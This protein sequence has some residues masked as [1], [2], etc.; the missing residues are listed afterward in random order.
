MY[1]N[2]NYTTQNSPNKTNSMQRI[3]C[4][5]KS[6]SDNTGSTLTAAEHISA[7]IIPATSDSKTLA[8][9]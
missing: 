6:F 7:H 4:G 3:Q 2:A 1:K 8:V 9:A 5:K